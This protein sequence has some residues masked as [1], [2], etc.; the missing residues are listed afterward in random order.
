MVIADQAALAVVAFDRVTELGG[1]RC[2]RRVRVS[3]LADPG[4]PV[5]RLSSLTAASNRCHSPSGPRRPL[6]GAQLVGRVARRPVSRP[7]VAGAVRPP[8]DLGLEPGGLGQ[9]RSAVVVVGDHTRRPRDRFLSGHRAGREHVTLQVPVVALRS[10]DVGVLELARTYISEL[11]AASQ[12]AAAVWRSACS[13]MS[14]RRR[15]SASPC[16]S[17]ARPYCDPGAGRRRRSPTGPWSASACE[18]A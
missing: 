13:G 5:A 8:A 2:D 7:L 1:D 14:R 9:R 10:A 6:S 11:P 4:R 3:D 12:A 16:A 17:H 18:P 15:P